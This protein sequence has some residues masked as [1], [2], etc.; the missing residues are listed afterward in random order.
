GQVVGSAVSTDPT[1]GDLVINLSSVTPLGTY[2]VAVQGASGQVFDVGGYRLSI[3]SVPLVNNLVGGAG[4]TAQS[5]LQLLNN[6]LHT[7]DSFLTATLL[8]TLG[9]NGQTTDAHFDQAYR[10]SLSDSWDVDY[11]M[12]R[13]PQTAAGDNALVV[14]A[15]RLG[16]SNLQ[17]KVAIYDANQHLINAE[18]LVNGD[19]TAVL[20]VAGAQAGGTYYVKVSAASGLS[21]GGDNYFLGVDFSPRAFHLLT[22]A[23]NTLSAANTSDT[24]TLTVS[25]TATFHFVLSADSAPGT[26]VRMT[27][28]DNAGALVRVLEV[29]SG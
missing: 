14:T 2:Y 3:R 17:P 11:Y 22:F 16:S 12:V 7:N 28:R 9:L 15:W 24:G 10:A 21:Q 18:V 27:I 8:G 23:D 5:A 26:K 20:Q 4:N 19:G 29:A 6:D 13:A 25:H 1:G